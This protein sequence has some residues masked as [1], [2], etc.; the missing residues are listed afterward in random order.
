MKSKLILISILF[1]SSVNSYSQTKKELIKERDNYKKLYQNLLN[2][3]SLKEASK[4]A[5]W[6]ATSELKQ[7]NRYKKQFNEADLEFDLEILRSV[8]SMDKE[9]WLYLLDNGFISP[10]DYLYLIKGSEELAL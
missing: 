10:N 3:K 4:I 1:L 5:S 7:S 9:R 6:Q 2:E 8:F